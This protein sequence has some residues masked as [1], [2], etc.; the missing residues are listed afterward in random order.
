M[1]M[2]MRSHF[3]VVIIL[4]V[5]A[6]STGAGTSPAPTTSLRCFNLL[7]ILEEEGEWIVVMIPKESAYEL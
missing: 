1:Y 3:T 2:Y 7:L 5:T 4:V 6:A